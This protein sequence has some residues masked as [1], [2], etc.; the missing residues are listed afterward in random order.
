MEHEIQY[1]DDIDAYTEGERWARSGTE[2]DIMAGA[3]LQVDPIGV[4][5]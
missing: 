2:A 5:V 4:A 1:G 3:C